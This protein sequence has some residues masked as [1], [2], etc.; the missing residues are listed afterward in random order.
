[1]LENLLYKYYAAQHKKKQDALNI[2]A[3][4]RIHWWHTLYRIK[5]E[6]I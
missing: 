1:M 5:K 2:F 4:N 3:F 6:L